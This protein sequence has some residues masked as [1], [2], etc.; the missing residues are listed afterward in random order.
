MVPH[1][2]TGIFYDV[3]QPIKTRMSD[4]KLRSRSEL[5]MQ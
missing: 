2:G 5:L 4:S 1:E 3:Y